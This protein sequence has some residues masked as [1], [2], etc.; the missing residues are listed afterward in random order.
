[1]PPAVENT[2]QLSDNTFMW[3]S[4]EIYDA[5]AYWKTE[6][7]L[8]SRIEPCPSEKLARLPRT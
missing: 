5:A 1:M 4:R 3:K 6:I 2:R 7:S 8:P